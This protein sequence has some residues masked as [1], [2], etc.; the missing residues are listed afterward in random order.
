MFYNKCL[1]SQL[2]VN[3]LEINLSVTKPL[4]PS[5]SQND[6]ITWKNTKRSALFSVFLI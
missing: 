4:Q 3:K 5:Q 6:N 1:K 2:F